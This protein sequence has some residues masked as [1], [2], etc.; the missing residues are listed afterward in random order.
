MEG[1]A[2]RIARTGRGVDDEHGDVAEVARH[3]A[4]QHLRVP[5]RPVPQEDVPWGGERV[6]VHSFDGRCQP[7]PTGGWTLQRG[8]GGGMD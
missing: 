2:G 6:G 8:G 7:H 5:R 3:A 1:A 4:L